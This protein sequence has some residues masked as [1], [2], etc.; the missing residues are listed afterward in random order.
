MEASFAMALDVLPA[1]PWDVRAIRADGGPVG[2]RLLAARDGRLHCTLDAVDVESGLELTIPV[3]LPDR[4][5]FSVVCAVEEIVP[6]GASR[7]AADLRVVE[8]ARR[9]PFRGDARDEARTPAVLWVLEAVNHGVGTEL[10]GWAVDVS[11][12]GIG[13]MVTALLQSGDRLLVQTRHDG[14]GIQGEVEVLGVDRGAEGGWRA[15][16]R[17]T[18][19]PD[20]TRAELEARFG[21]AA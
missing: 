16:C 7:L 13:F 18:D 15:A 5:G 17:F 2:L 14:V 20:E 21:R 3:E 1:A 19:L 11:A 6:L 10:T 4:G 12:G 9:K 8:V